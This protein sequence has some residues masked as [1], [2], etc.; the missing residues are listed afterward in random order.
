MVKR[1]LIAILVLIGFTFLFKGS[2]F[3]TTTLSS[4]SDT[5]STSRPSPSSTIL[6]NDQAVN[7]TQVK[8]Y[9]N[10]SI[11][12]ASDSATFRQDPVTATETTDSG[13][14][15]ASMSASASTARFVY[16]TQT[17]PHAH[18]I[19][20]AVVVPITAMHT[21]KFTT[22]TAIPTLGKITI[23]FPSLTSGDA[24]Q[25]ASASASTFQLNGIGASQI[26]VNGLSGAAT[27]TVS[28]TN[29]AVGTNG[30]VVLTFTGTTNVPV[31]T[32]VTVFLGCN[33]QSAGACTTQAPR[34][35]NPTKTKAA[36]SADT[37]RINLTT[38]DVTNSTD[39]DTGRAVIGTVESVQVQAQI[40]PT[41][42][43]TIAGLN[44]GTN[45]NTIT[46]CPSETSNSGIN[47]TA[48]FVNLGTVG[49][50]IT[51]AGQEITVSTN[52]TG[53]YALTATSSGTLINPASGYSVVSSTSYGTM[54]AGTELFG[55]H[56][57]GTDA[58]SSAVPGSAVSGGGGGKVAW[59]TQTTNISLASRTSTANAINTGIEYAITASNVTPEG[60]YTSVITYVATATFN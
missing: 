5:I 4:V 19:G 43:F 47:A 59:P 55:I 30:S 41:L 18:H 56:P 11:F 26:A 46:S 35:I 28:T 60:I 9:D 15:V 40:D 21:I 36:G 17:I 14:N 2:V 8:V 33:T 48:T 12:L 37:W 1:S 23:N 54:T 31:N 53:G 7:D 10:G 52:G 57:C 34:L 24:N 27:Y 39:L 45:F 58:V 44:N 6:T 42:T 49:T 25:A 22:A 29:P 13:I 32:V 3:A 16:F 51:I 38:T 50:G 20:D